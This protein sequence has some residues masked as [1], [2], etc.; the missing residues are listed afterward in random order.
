MQLEIST[1]FKQDNVKVGNVD[2]PIEVV[3]ISRTG[4]AFKT[5]SILPLNYYFNSMIEIGDKDSR[6]YCVVRIIRREKN[7]QGENIYGCEFIGFAPVLNHVFDELEA[8]N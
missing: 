2:A 8:E 7:E 4:I 5:E 6:F 3:N 1:L